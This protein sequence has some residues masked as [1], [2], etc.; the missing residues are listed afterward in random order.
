MLAL[1][2]LQHSTFAPLVGSVFQVKT[3]AG[4]ELRLHEAKLLGHRRANASRDPFSLVFR[5]PPGLRI[6]QGIHRMETSALGEME[7]FI[8]QISAGPHGADFEAVF[9]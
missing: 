1:E 7:I 5:G 3:G 2:L 9:T 4:A 6:E 8:T